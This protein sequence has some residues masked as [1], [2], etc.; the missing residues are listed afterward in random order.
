MK[1]NR[2]AMEYPI[3][4]TIKSLL[5]KELSDLEEYLKADVLTYH[6]PIFDGTEGAFLQIVEQLNQRKTHDILF[7]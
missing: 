4:D 3:N 1:I 5:N 2:K 6:G 7:M